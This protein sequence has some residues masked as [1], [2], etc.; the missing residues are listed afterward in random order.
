M[1]QKSK[2]SKNPAVVFARENK[3]DSEKRRNRTR[4]PDNMLLLVLFFFSSSR[5]GSIFRVLASFPM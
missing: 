4:M 5:F 1:E 3:K 2:Q